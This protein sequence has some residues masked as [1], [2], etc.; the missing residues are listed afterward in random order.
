MSGK[1]IDTSP[2]EVDFTDDDQADEGARY[3]EFVYSK[4]KTP[5]AAD[6]TIA[7]SIRRG[8]IIKFTVGLIIM[9]LFQILYW[10]NEMFVKPYL[11]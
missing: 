10:I 2:V 6:Y 5:T 8:K 1:P 9:N 11:P 7:H 3:L 4:D